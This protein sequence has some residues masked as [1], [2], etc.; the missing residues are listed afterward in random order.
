MKSPAFTLIEMSIVLLVIA[1]IIAAI[2]AS[3]HLLDAAKM[4]SVISLQ[5]SLQADIKAFKLTYNSLPGDF[6]N[7]SILWPSATCVTGDANV[8]S[9]Y[10]NGNGDGMIAGNIASS[11]NATAEGTLVLQHLSLAQ[12]L[13][14]NYIGGSNLFLAGKTIV[15]SSD[16]AV[17]Y[18]ALYSV[19]ANAL[20]ANSYVNYGNY[21]VLSKAS[22]VTSS[23]NQPGAGALT[24]AKAQQIDIKI[25]DGFPTT[26]YSLAYTGYANVSSNPC[27]VT[28]GTNMVYNYLLNEQVCVIMHL[29][30]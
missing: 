8:N 7:A 27:V 18:N 30:K 10:C 19:T 4:R 15:I 17:G 20:A 29:I 14:G 12:I 26:G 24:P 11:I 2:S 22:T 9:N 1:I 16:E 28:S 13:K 25:D 5:Q 21:L 3:T 23:L 6:K